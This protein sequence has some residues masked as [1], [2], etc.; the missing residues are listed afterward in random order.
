MMAIIETIISAVVGSILSYVKLWYDQAEA[1]ENEW[2]AKTREAQLRSIKDADKM[3]LEIKD[4]KPIKVDSPSAWNLTPLVFV[5]ILLLSPGCGL[6]TKYV[7][8]PSKLPYIEVP[9][10]PQIPALPVAWTTREVLLKDYA[11]DLETKVTKY[12]KIAK[13]ENIKNGYEDAPTP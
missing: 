10:R 8:V 3:T 12:N 4:A 13:R 9:V 1:A 5:V 6:F 11:L 2:N 7:H